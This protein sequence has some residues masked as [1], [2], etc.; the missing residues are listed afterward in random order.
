MFPQSSTLE[1]A[2]QVPVV[3]AE[4]DLQVVSALEQLALLGYRQ[5]ALTPF[6]ALWQFDLQFD[7]RLN[8]RLRTKVQL[9]DWCLKQKLDVVLKMV[10][11]AE[12]SLKKQVPVVLAEQDL[13][14]VSALERLVLVIPVVFAAQLLVQL[15]AELAQMRLVQVVS[16]LERLVLVIPVVFAAQL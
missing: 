15:V 8:F 13:Q 12:A 4:Q 9:H 2:K 7:F 11:L 10:R 14:V 3:L 16:A 6:E 1:L 5:L